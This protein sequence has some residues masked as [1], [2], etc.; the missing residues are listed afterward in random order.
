MLPR[1]I[2]FTMERKRK[3]ER[4]GEKRDGEE[5]MQQ[6]FRSRGRDE[7]PKNFHELR[8]ASR[9]I[10]PRVVIYLPEEIS[11]EIIIFN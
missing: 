10:D 6:L 1:M 9:R 4:K 8:R 3:R 5:R 2:R 7:S 11:D